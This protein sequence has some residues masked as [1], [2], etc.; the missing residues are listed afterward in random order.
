MTS[1]DGSQ[2]SGSKVRVNTNE[3]LTHLSTISGLNMEAL[4]VLVAV[5]SYLERCAQRLERLQP[6]NNLPLRKLLSEVSLAT[7]TLTPLIQSMHLS[8]ERVT[9]LERSIF[10]AHAEE[11]FS[12]SPAKD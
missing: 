9:L 6:N 7:D 1:Q 3:F 10:I 4:G 12:G 11:K 2:S 5:T 8:N